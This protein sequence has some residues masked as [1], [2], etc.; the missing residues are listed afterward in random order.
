MTLDAEKVK[1]K[2]RKGAFLLEVITIPILPVVNRHLSFRGTFR[3]LVLHDD[4]FIAIF[5][6][7][8][9]QFAHPTQHLC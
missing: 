3:V 7:H 2:P 8:F 5:G 1:T 9:R 4:T 6:R